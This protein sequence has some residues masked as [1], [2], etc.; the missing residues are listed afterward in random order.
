MDMGWTAHVREDLIACMAIRISGKSCGPGGRFHEH[1]EQFAY[2]LLS[3]EKLT[4]PVDLYKS[5]P[6][7]IDGDGYHEFVMGA[8]GGSGR[9]FDAEGHEYGTLG[10]PAALAMKFLDLPGEQLLIYQEDGTV[11]FWA[12]ANAR[13]TDVAVARY[14]HPMYDANRRLPACGYNW[15]ALGGL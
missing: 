13:D 2:N 12:D 8:P 10:G 4:L 1:Y 7:D 14:R 9:V 15:T 11:S 3:G 5:L 6:V